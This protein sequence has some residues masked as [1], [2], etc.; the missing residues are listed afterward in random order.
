MKHALLAPVGFVSSLLVKSI[1]LAASCPESATVPA[2][3]LS[4]LDRHTRNK[5]STDGRNWGSEAVCKRRRRQILCQIA[6]LP[7]RLPA[8]NC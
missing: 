8:A 2:G 6:R 5:Y 4:L 3:S 1:G 7:A